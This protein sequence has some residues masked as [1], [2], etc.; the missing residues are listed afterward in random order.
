MMH[1]FAIHIRIVWL[2]AHEMISSFLAILLGVVTQI[3]PQPPSPSGETL[4]HSPWS[5]WTTESESLANGSDRKCID[6][7]RTRQV[8]SS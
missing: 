1:V 8:P 7:P 6:P 2:N 5:P 4:R 3:Q